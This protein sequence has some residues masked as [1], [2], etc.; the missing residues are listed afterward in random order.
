M[1]LINGFKHSFPH[2]QAIAFGEQLQYT[3]N[4][5]LT[6]AGPEATARQTNP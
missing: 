3:S 5:S 4:I 2:Q 1:Q 6:E